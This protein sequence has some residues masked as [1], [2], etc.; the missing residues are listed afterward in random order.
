MENQVIE[1]NRAPSELK[2]TQTK[3]IHSVNDPG[4]LINKFSAN[5]DDILKHINK[6]SAENTTLSNRIT[7][8]QIQNI[9]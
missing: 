7:V 4:R 3:F 6:L 9:K 8:R 1:M 5:F 2:T